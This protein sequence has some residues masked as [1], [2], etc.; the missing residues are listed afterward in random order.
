LT[1]LRDPLRYYLTIARVDAFLPDATFFIIGLQTVVLVILSSFAIVFTGIG[2]R[3]ERASVLS[4][5]FQTPMDLMT[6][7]Q[8]PDE[9]LVLLVLSLGLAL[10]A[11]API[12]F[13]YRF[14]SRQVRGPFAVVIMIFAVVSFDGLALA[15]V[16]VGNYVADQ[17][18]YRD[19]FYFRL[20]DVSCR[21]MR[22]EAP[23]IVAL[24]T[25][26]NVSSEV[27]RLD[28]NDFT[29]ALYADRVSTDAPPRNPRRMPNRIGKKAKQ[30]SVVGGSAGNAP[31]MLFIEPNKSYWY[32]IS[33]TIDQEYI[34]FID[35]HPDNMKCYVSYDH[36]DS[37]ISQ[38]G[39]LIDEA[40]PERASE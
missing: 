27:W 35:S 28:K 22:G 13:V 12:P 36:T 34:G 26:N 1:S 7:N 25:V 29:V 40:G 16:R 24:V 14:A 3:E 4:A 19:R 10:V 37:F 32:R 6:A 21:L 15:V 20:A 11:M 38:H 31:E 17:I 5:L 9:R 8:G 2:Y 23:R 18:S 33:A 39:A 30:A